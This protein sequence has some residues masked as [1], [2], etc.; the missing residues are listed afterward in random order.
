MNCPPDRTLLVT[1]ALL[2]ELGINSFPEGRSIIV[3]AQEG[4]PPCAELEQALASCS[5]GP[6]IQFSRLSKGDTSRRT[7]HLR[8]GCRTYPTSLFVE[9]DHIRH[10]IE[11][12]VVVDGQ[13][14]LSAH[15]NFLC[16][17]DS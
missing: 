10:R 2:A 12:R 17:A 13:T 4:C 3:V 9:N 5:M 11:G 7:A 8:L 16:E 15:L 6:R 14:D 1:D